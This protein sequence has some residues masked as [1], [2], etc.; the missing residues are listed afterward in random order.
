V[1]DPSRI[2]QEYAD[3]LLATLVGGCLIGFGIWT[4]L[5][6]DLAAMTFRNAAARFP[7]LSSALLGSLVNDDR[8]SR[9]FVLTVSGAIAALGVLSLV[10][11]LR[12]L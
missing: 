5:H 10:I 1:D 2:I 6:R 9:I 4:V 8:A 7:R 12:E 3:P 11:A